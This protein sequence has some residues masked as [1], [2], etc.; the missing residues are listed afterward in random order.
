[1]SLRVD[2]FYL[3]VNRP[4]TIHLRLSSHGRPRK[5]ELVERNYLELLQNVG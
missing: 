3:P 2:Q 5:D 4:A 1:M